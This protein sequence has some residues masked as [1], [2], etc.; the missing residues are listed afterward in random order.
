MPAQ[1]P[2]HDLVHVPLHVPQQL[3]IQVAGFSAA[4]ERIGACV[5]AITP[6]IG[7]ALFAAFLKNSRLD[8][9]SSFF[10]CSFMMN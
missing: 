2:L 9:S 7:K 6:K 8:W 4:C 3:P 1:L 10:F 5:R